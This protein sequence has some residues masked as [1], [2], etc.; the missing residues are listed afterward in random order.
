MNGIVLPL[1]RRVRGVRRR[2]AATARPVRGD[3]LPSSLRQTLARTAWQRRA[4]RR[5]PRGLPA[6]L[7]TQRLGR[8]AAVFRATGRGREGNPLPCQHCQQL[9][10]QS[11]GSGRRAAGSSPAPRPPHGRSARGRRG[12]GRLRLVDSER[13]FAFR[14]IFPGAA[15]FGS[16]ALRQN[17]GGG[18]IIRQKFR[19]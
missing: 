12:G 6:P 17:V 2:A 13:D 16:A 11:S 7:G 4:C 18:A 14:M 5:L 1:G 8:R 3:P 9:G 10:R 19:G 15:V